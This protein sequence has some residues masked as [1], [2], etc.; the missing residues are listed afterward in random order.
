MD[1]WFYSE[2]D[3][4]AN[5]YVYIHRNQSIN[6]EGFYILKNYRVSGEMVVLECSCHPM[7]PIWVLATIQLHLSFPTTFTTVACIKQEAKHVY[8]NFIQDCF[9]YECHG[10]SYDSF[11][12]KVIDYLINFQDKECDSPDRRD[13]DTG[14]SVINTPDSQTMTSL[15]VAD[16]TVNQEID[17]YYYHTFI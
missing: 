4:S 12:T 1:T 15:E 16:D 17:Y 13:N 9:T 7:A 2:S 6:Q 3:N 11:V 14:Q 8:N 10:M 5:Y